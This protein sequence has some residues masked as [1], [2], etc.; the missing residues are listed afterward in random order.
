MKYGIIE[1]HDNY[2]FSTPIAYKEIVMCQDC[3]SFNENDGFHWCK[4]WNRNVNANG[5]CSHGER[6]GE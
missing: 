1:L 5:Y 6:E 2:D 4:L 3:R